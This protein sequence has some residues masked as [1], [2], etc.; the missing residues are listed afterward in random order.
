MSAIEPRAGDILRG[1][2]WTDRVERDSDL[3]DSDLR[4][5][6]LRDADLTGSDLRGA[7]LTGGL[8]R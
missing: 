5:A 3:R 4:D 6:D 1:V 8:T 7:D 2:D